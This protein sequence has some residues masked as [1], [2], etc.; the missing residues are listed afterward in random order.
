MKHVLT[1]TRRDPYGYSITY[2]DFGT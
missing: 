1:V 2:Q